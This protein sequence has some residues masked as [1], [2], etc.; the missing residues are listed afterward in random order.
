MKDQVLHIQRLM[1]EVMQRDS[2]Y[3]V[4]PGCGDKP[5]LLKSGAEK[6]CFTFRMAPSFVVS[7][8]NLGGGHREY[9][10]EC[11]LEHIGTGHHLGSGVGSC[12]TMESKYRY[13]TKTNFIGPVPQE[14]WKTRDPAL[15]PPPAT[16]TKKTPNG[17]MAVELQREDNQDLADVYN[18]VIKMAKKRAMVDA[19]LTATAASDIFTQDIEEFHDQEEEPA[20]TPPQNNQQQRPPAGKAQTRSRTQQKKDTPPDQGP[21]PAENPISAKQIGFIHAIVSKLATTMAEEDDF[22]RWVIKKEFLFATPIQKCS[23]EMLSSA[24]GSRMIDILRNGGDQMFHTYTQSVAGGTQGQFEMDD[25]PG[26]RDDD[27]PF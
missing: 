10:V 22:I 6:L 12:S 20:P 17:W 24:N 15:L 8:N 26:T 4:I 19:V 21:P 13:R 9:I 7:M 2:H 25:T 3:G 18:T 23:L 5:S 27:V 16:R 1:K 11:R 14:Y